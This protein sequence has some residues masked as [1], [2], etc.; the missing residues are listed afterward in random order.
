MLLTQLYIYIAFIIYLYC[1]FHTALYVESFLT[2]NLSSLMN[3]KQFLRG[4][5]QKASPALLVMFFKAAKRK[6]I[7]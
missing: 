2:W 3:V 4:F 7:F 6:E 1:L 5:P